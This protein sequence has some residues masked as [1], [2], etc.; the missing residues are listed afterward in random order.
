MSN[1]ECSLLTVRQAAEQLSVTEAAIRR[2]LLERG[3]ASVKVGRRLI[4][5]PVSEV[6]RLVEAGLRPARPAR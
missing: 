2:W 1:S 3:I 4:R 5:I 6:Q